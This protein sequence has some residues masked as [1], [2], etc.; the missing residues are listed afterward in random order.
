M[1]SYSREVPANQSPVDTQNASDCSHFAIARLEVTLVAFSVDK[2]ETESD[3][4]FVFLMDAPIL[5]LCPPALLLS[6][7]EKNCSARTPTTSMQDFLF[8]L[9]TDKLKSID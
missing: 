3:H 6:S 8:F 9:S 4:V 7:L 2:Q 5:V 1:R